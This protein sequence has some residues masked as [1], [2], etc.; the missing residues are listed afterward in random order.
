MKKQEQE[1]APS[2]PGDKVHRSP[3]PGGKNNSAVG[4]LS[5]LQKTAGNQA[6]RGMLQAGVIKAKLRVSQPGDADELEAEREAERVTSDRSAESPGS[7]ATSAQSSG[8]ASGLGVAMSVTRSL[9]LDGGHRLEIEPFVFSMLMIVL[10][11]PV[12]CR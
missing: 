7:S 5:Q 2:H 11:W 10:S 6:L 12:W 1:R 8:S 3:K 9:T 4:P